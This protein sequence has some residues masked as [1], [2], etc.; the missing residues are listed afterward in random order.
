VFAAAVALGVLLHAAPH[1][2][3]HLSPEPDDMEGV[4]DTVVS[5]WARASVAHATARTVSTAR[6]GAMSWVSLNTQ[7]DTLALGTAT[8]VSA[9]APS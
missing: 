2:V 6:G 8:F 3:D 1:L 7:S 4:E 9:T 5:S